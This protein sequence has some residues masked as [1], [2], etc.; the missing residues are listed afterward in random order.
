[1]MSNGWMVALDIGGTFAK[2]IPWNE[3]RA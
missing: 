3:G 2:A 1:M